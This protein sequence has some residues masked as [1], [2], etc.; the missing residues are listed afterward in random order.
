[1][2]NEID[3]FQGDNKT[4]ELTVKNRAGAVVDITS[5]TIKFTVKKLLD[6]TATIITKTTAEAT[7]VTITDGSNGVA[8]I[9]VVPADTATEERG[10]YEYD[11]EYT[12]V[13]GKKYTIIVSRFT[14]KLEGTD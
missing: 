9:Y 2:T 8:E 1:M 13:S 10:E 12:A 5:G 6:D 4:Y 7:E 3:I 11:V 14:I